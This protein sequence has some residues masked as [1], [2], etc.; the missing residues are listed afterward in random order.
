MRKSIVYRILFILI[1]L[2]VLFVLNTVLSGVTNSQ[3]QLST[4]LISDS[5]LS[6]EYNQ[7]NL[8]KNITQINQT[9]GS[10]FLVEEDK[11]TEDIIQSI[12]DEVNR[13]ETI[14]KNIDTI[15]DEYSVKAMN[16][17]MSDSY[18]PYLADME[19]Y[20]KHALSIADFIKTKD[21]I[22]AKNTYQEFEVLSNSMAEKE[23]AFQKVLD[24]NINHETNLVHA[25]V[26]RS[27]III[28]GMA[29]VFVL[30]VAVA[31][32]VC[33]K[34]III[35]LKK[36][37][38]NLGEIIDKLE[39]DEGDLTTRIEYMYD[40]EVGQ[41][42]KGIN[43]FLETL[44][45]VI[46]SIKSGSN[47]IYHSTE[48]MNDHL[49]E[50]KDS[51]SSISGALN[52]MSAS[53]EEINGTLQNIDNGAQNVLHA[54]NTIEEEANS[55]T[56]QVGEI[57]EHAESVRVQ[58][59]ESKKKTE[60]VLQDIGNKISVSI[61]KSRSVEKINEL[62]N[63]ILGISSQ[64][65]LLALNASIEAA[66]AGNAGKGFAIVADEIRKLAEDTKDI[67]SDIQDTNT[68]VIDS[69][70]DLV[71][72]ANEIMT[73]VTEKVICDYDG[74]VD[75]ANTYKQ[76]ADVINEMLTRFTTKSK[77]LREVATDMANGIKGITIAVDESVNAV[78]ESNE[79]TNTL[80]HSITSISN[81]AEHN[82][83]IVNELNL[84]VNK[85]KRVEE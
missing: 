8:T 34:T 68:L 10:Y 33:R 80:A 61:E 25:R 11:N 72:N 2:T 36:V 74:F 35:P 20:L 39:K 46:I 58:S 62:T 16:R 30:S 7:V 49:L 18:A 44:Q 28:W 5:F 51:T 50:C 67:A 29:I 59:N 45:Q 57:V 41:I 15:C 38:R 42:S 63:T 53:M 69:V 52:E 71:Q 83:E 22:S 14:V 47:T 37:N 40:D 64:T 43:R 26:T 12:Q 4:S 77:E 78:I 84:E 65:N 81:E 24:E 76:D 85:F 27:T 55:N 21:K 1:F 48:M 54:A 66:R 13:T 31:F 3:V 73:Y 56:V 70:E 9:I 6:L 19:N 60:T 23:K 17:T 82:W 32:Y 75:V 79:D